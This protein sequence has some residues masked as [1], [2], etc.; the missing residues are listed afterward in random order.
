MTI[1]YKKNSNYRR[2]PIENNELGQYVPPVQLDYSKTQQIEL[3]Q[4][5]DR[6][7]D[8]LAYDLYGDAQLW[9]IFVHYNRNVLLDPIHDFTT[10]TT[11]FAPTRDNLTGL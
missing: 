9:W 5:Y 2:T 7:P 11:I 4:R 10:G 6:R 3:T 8:I 1:K